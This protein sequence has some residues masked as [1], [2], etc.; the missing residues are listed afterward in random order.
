MTVPLVGN[1]YLRE[2]KGVIYKWLSTPPWTKLL[3]SFNNSWNTWFSDSAHQRSWK[4]SRLWPHNKELELERALNIVKCLLCPG[5][6]GG[7]WAMSICVLLLVKYYL[8]SAGGKTAP[9]GETAG[10]RSHSEHMWDALCKPRAGSGAQH[11]SRAAAP[12]GRQGARVEAASRYLE[13][14][15][16]GTSATHWKPPLKRTWYPISANKFYLN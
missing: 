10:P 14:I 2:G 13:L 5:R 3:S 4:A 7:H 16:N 12:P 1:E 6:Q 8:Y 11:V 9:Q 15:R